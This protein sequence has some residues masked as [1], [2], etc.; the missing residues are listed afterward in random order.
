MRFFTQLCKNYVKR[1]ILHSKS[2]VM[3]HKKPHEYWINS[4]HAPV[5]QW[6]EQTFPNLF[7]SIK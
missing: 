3:L 5:A 4:Y 2:K 1:I 6:I 7:N